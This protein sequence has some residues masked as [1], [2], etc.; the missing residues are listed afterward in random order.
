MKT[1][2]LNGSWELRVSG[3]DHRVPAVVPGSVYHDLL[4]AG[5]IPD[6]FYRDNEI[7]ALKLME[8][9]FSYSREFEVSEEL[10]SSDTVLL[11]CEG[12]D[13]LAEITVNESWKSIR[14]DN[15]HR[16]WE[17]DVKKVL[18]PGVNT[19]RISF[20]SPTE[21][22]KKAYAENPADG[23]SDAM[24]GFPLLRKAHCMFGWD[25][26][27][28]LPDAGIWR[29]IS[30]IGIDKARL[31][32]V[33]VHQEHNRD[34]SVTLTVKPEVKS[35]DDTA[36]KAETKQ[37]NISLLKAEVKPSAYKNDKMTFTVCVISPDGYVRKE[38][39][40]CSQSEITIDINDPVLW[41][42]NGLGSQPL[43]TVSVT[44]MYG[45]KELDRWEKRIGLRTLTVSRRKDKW[46]TTFCHTVNG[47]D[48]FAM[49]ADYIP[50]DNLIPRVTPERTRRLLEDAV[51]ANMNCIR[52]WGGGYY[53]DD[54]F[55]DICDEL[56]LLVWQ[57]FMF[58]CAVYNLTDDFERTIRAEFT[59][60]IRRLRHHASLALWCG[61]NEMES[62]VLE[63]EWVRNKR[64]A[65]DYIKMYEYIIP[66]VLKKE[67]PD[68]FYWPSSPSSGGS[69]EK[70][71][72][73][74]NG[75]V[76][77]WQVWH[78][79]KPF[80]DYRNHMFRY[81]SEFGFQSFPCME[82]IESFTLPED[83]NAFSYVMEKH[84]RNASANGKI[85]AYL[86]QTYLYPLSF[87]IFVYASQLLQAQA[88]QY[89]VEHWRRNRTDCRC[90]GAV[91][92]QLNDCWPVVSWASIDYYG[93]WKALHY[94]EKRFFA[95]VLISCH[96]EGILSQ[97]TNVNAEPFDLKKTA[98]LNVSNETLMQFEG[99]ASWA[100][101]RPDASIIREG[102]FEV[103]VPPM[104]A[105]WLEELDFHD[106]DTY[107][108]YF[109]YELRSKSENI[110][111]SGTVLFC[112]PKHF[113]FEDPHL[114]AVIEGD[115]IV[116]TA[117]AYA[118]SVEIMCSADTLLE[119]N[120]F[121][122][123]AGK[124][125]IKI[126]RGEPEKAAARSVYDIGR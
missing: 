61:N 48:V 109:S 115:E 70:P 106:E 16:T 122:M 105:V 76:H 4:T 56:G 103:S 121:D 114:K 123:N 87:D 27:P 69:F 38:A 24:M 18:H 39:V 66:Q 73:P 36:M 47:V 21:F 93:R 35:V 80:T 58:A 77:Y 55:Y 119:D 113:R 41:W 74:D 31:E 32:S 83:R 50:E 101:R 62:F 117:D 20:F 57:D 13:T 98:R 51:L 88:I 95:P 28:R 7:E 8:H 100:L 102:C 96:E 46:G 30:I 26:G 104:S 71:Q 112:P 94:Y 10:L 64:Q 60:N 82:T 23:T 42:P 84:Q 118:K 5:E 120:F 54:W 65:A 45:D 43:Y 29:N 126:L 52:V 111:G 37:N 14:T 44:L 59:D 22:I 53:P 99:N 108:C 63:G 25:W 1:L 89:G 33:Y 6:P 124:R 15:M 91:V 107:G 68:T 125:R 90:M 78:G 92:W 11:R 3:W 79:E 49:G 34:G 85:A 110:V 75:D 12:L 86:A 72:D 17:F 9:N 81:A 67:D 19:I 40:P 2:S 116:V 97:N